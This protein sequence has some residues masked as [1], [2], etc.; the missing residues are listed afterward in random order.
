[1][2][3]DASGPPT[4]LT[5][6]G[7]NIGPIRY[8]FTSSR[9]L[10][11]NSGVKSIS[12]STVIAC[13]AYAGGFVGNG[14]V[15][16]YHSPGTSPCGAA[17]SSIGHTGWPVTRSNTYRND[18]LLGNATALIAFPFTTISASSGAEERS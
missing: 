13:R 12:S 5:T 16:E 17:R 2:V 3:N 4:L 8:I 11:R 14:C 10:L 9:A 7:R 1:M 6:A 15:G 18:S